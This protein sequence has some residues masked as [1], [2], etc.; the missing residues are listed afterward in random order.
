MKGYLD[1]LA[2]R[3][4]EPRS[5]I[6]P[7]PLSRF[8]IPD[9]RTTFVEEV[10]IAG[11]EDALPAPPT[12]ARPTRAADD[13]GDGVRQFASSAPPLRAEAIENPAGPHP[14]SVTNDITAAPSARDALIAQERDVRVPSRHD[15][16]SAMA[17]PAEAPLAHRPASGRA[18]PAA[19]PASLEALPTSQSAAVPAASVPTAQDA[20][21]L[22]GIEDRISPWRAPA[23]R[24]A[25]PAIDTL[26]TAQG[27]IPTAMPQQRDKPG[28]A[29]DD[30]PAVVQ[31]TIGRLEVRAPEP[32]RRPFAKPTRAAPRMS[33][34][35]YLQRRTEGRVR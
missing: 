16:G 20:I 35:D 32:P 19:M 34:Q 4:V 23:E 9:A 3:L 17:E 27:T 33:L 8:E 6:R 18:I 24:R 25:E 14:A 28:A 10:G 11:E 29:V 2:A 7:R 31:V 13:R 5:H 30:T 12:R 21:V 26:T 1:R 15:L 22:P